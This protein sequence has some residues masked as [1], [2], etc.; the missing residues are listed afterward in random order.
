MAEIGLVQILEGALMAAGEALSIQRLS[1]LFDEFDRPANSDLREALDEV[2]RRC[3]GRGYELV[4]VATGYR[5][6]VRQN[7][8]T[9][10]GRLWQERPPRYSRALLETLSLIAYRQ[11]ITRGEIEEIRGVAVSTNIIKTLQERDWVRIVGHRDVPGRPAMYATTRQFLDYFNLKSL[12]ELPP[13][14]EI[15]DLENLSGNLPLE[16]LGAEVVET[17]EETQAEAIPANTEDENPD[18]SPPEEIAPDDDKVLAETALEEPGLEEQAMAEEASEEGVSLGRTFDDQLAEDAA[19]EE[20]AAGEGTAAA[21][22]FE[23]AASDDHSPVNPASDEQ[24]SDGE[25]RH[26]Q[27]PTPSK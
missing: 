23:Q 25:R 16:I 10:V 9:W 12:E 5:F 24:N 20:P 6:Q 3:E 21:Q 13:L 22:V 18:E 4:Q 8:S 19:L 15:K 14:A 11:P 26:E 17:E 27:S 1:Q 2:E 7:L